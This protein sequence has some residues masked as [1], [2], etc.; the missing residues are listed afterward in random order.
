VRRTRNAKYAL[1]ANSVSVLVDPINIPFAREE[2][3]EDEE[4]EDE[5]EDE[6]EEEDDKDETNKD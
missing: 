6:E 1:E 2:D 3:E 5:K 4:E